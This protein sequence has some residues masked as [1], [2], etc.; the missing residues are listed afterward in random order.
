MKISYAIAI[1]AS[2]L[3]LCLLM[4]GASATHEHF[5]FL[6]MTFSSHLARGG[7]V[8]SMIFGI[9]TFLVAYGSSLPAH[10]T[11]RRH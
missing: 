6:G 7:G 2:L 5:V 11:N 8:I 4:V 3:G 1:A 9:V 10:Q